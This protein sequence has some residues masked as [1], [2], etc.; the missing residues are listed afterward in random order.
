MNILG[1]AENN[2]LIDSYLTYNLGAVRRITA[3][4]TRPRQVEPQYIPSY[5]L[6]YWNLGERRWTGV[7]DDEGNN[8]VKYN[9]PIIYNILLH[10]QVLLMF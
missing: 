3:V 10:S 8:M 4:R 6:T 7:L 9:N 2:E 5:K 1:T